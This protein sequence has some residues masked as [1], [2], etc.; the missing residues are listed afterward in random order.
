MQIHTLSIA[1][2]QN[3]QFTLEM[4][5]ETSSK[6]VSMEMRTMLSSSLE[7][8]QPLQLII[9]WTVLTLITEKQE[10]TNIH[11]ILLRIFAKLT[12]GRHLIEL[13]D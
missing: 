7:L 3:K 6:G 11:Q 13:F 5:P 4:K 12:D 1:E 10:K 8:A 9:L 2:L